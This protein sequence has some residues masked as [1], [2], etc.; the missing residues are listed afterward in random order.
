VILVTTRKGSLGKPV[1]NYSNQFTFTGFTSYPEFLNSVQRATVLNEGLLN[2]GQQPFYTEEEIEA[3]RTGSD[4]INYPDENW[5]ELMFRDYG[6]QQRH[7]L[8]LSG[9]NERVRYFASAGFPGSGFQLH[10]D[11]LSYQQF[12]IRSNIDANITDNLILNLKLAGRRRL[13]EAPGYSANNIFPGTQP[14]PAHQSGLLPGWNPGAT[15][16]QSQPH[17]GRFKGFQRWLLPG[18]KQ[19]H[20]YQA[21]PAVGCTSRSEA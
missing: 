18:Q 4:P 14:G 2:A 20:R 10:E 13:N 8:N 1:L 21:L 11:V 19:Q 6:F 7:N 9:G 3:F 12:N 5:K 15:Q 17:P 16:F